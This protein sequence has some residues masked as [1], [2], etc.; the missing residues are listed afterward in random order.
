MKASLVLA[1]CFAAL[2]GSG[3]GGD[4]GGAELFVG[5]WMITSG[6]ETLQCQSLGVNDTSPVTGTTTISKGIDSPLVVVEDGCTTKY[7]VNGA[8]ASRPPD[9]RSRQMSGFT[10]LERVRARDL[11]A[12]GTRG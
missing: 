9:M 3:C 10:P 6:T 1:M 7:D 5:S 4:E 12:R 8:T 11:S 2:G